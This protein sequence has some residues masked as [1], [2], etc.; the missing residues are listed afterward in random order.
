MDIWG[1][2]EPALRDFEPSVANDVRSLARWVV[3]GDRARVE[4]ALPGMVEAARRARAPWVE[5]YVRH[6]GLQSSVV[7]HFRLGD[8]LREAAALVERAHRADARDCPQSVCAVQDLCIAY[9]RVDGPGYAAE[10]EQIARETLARIDASW[11][12]YRCIGSELVDALV[13]GG[14]P[15]DAVAWF[16]QGFDRAATRESLSPAIALARMG[17]CAEALALTEELELDL[18]ELGVLG[19][20]VVRAWVL[21]RLGRNEEANDALPA[22]SP[23]LAEAC[24]YHELYVEALVALLRRGVVSGSVSHSAQISHIVRTL[25]DNGAVRLPVRLANLWVSY[26]L[27]DGDALALARALLDAVGPLVP[28]LRHPG[29]DAD[30]F[31]SLQTRL[32]AVP[33]ETWASDEATA[34]AAFD[35]VKAGVRPFVPDI[36]D[37]TA[38]AWPRLTDLVVAVARHWHQR[39]WPE[40]AFELLDLAQAARPDAAAAWLARME[41]HAQRAEWSH[42]EALAES[43]P[44]PT[45]PA[46]SLARDR[47]RAQAAERRG[48][49]AA[50]LA[51]YERLL[52]EP[53]RCE[54]EVFERAATLYERQDRFEASLAV[55]DA[56]VGAEPGEL[57]R[58]WRRLIAASLASRWDVV[59]ADAA[60]LGLPVDPGEGVV[61]E[62]WGHVK[63]QHDDGTWWATRTGPVTAR[64]IDILAPRLPE[65]FGDVWV[66]DPV[67]VGSADGPTVFPTRRPLRVGDH[68][69]FA[70]DGVALPE[71]VW[72]AVQA[73]VA[74]QGGVSIKYSGDAYQLADGRA[75]GF[76]KVAIPRARFDAVAVSGALTTLTGRVGGPIVWLGVARAS[77]DGALVAA[78]VA[79]AAQ[80]GLD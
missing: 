67:P 65:R 13:D 73:Y 37:A 51:A 61:D 56:E 63:L 4:A 26:L 34:R 29:V 43:I 22:W 46:L 79:L 12:C 55:R 72:S 47:L 70:I 74:E 8:G 30:E 52:A 38:R 60:V 6:W 33:V 20:A 66:F 71:D 77:G 27:D 53:S 14:R 24:I 42:V 2:L 5:I 25:R 36:A 31:T 76:Y 28:R 69:G 49:V 16:E 23:L 18:G 35:E 7:R 11:P 64:V 80:W 17:R 58:R 40:I 75:A 54:P 41:I 32:Q 57:R 3:D 50:A 44:E 15:D 78:Q 68:V 48:D 9:G 39:G 45:D 1:W 10:R 59:R 21:T 19:K 62:D